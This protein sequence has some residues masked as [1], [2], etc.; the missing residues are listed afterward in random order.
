MYFWS[1]IWTK[2]N[3]RSK[4]STNK[5]WLDRTKVY[6]SISKEKSAACVKWISEILSNCTNAS[7]M[8]TINIW[9]CSIV[10]GVISWI[11]R[12]PFPIRYFLWMLH[13]IVW[14]RLFSDCRCCIR[15]IICIVTSSCKM[16]WLKTKMVKRYILL[17]ADLQNSWFWICQ[18]D[19]CAWFFQQK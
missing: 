14:A 1:R 16:C 13:W 15:A 12:Q 2:N 17:N 11:F 18:E 9:F 3:M 8:I 4:L 5:K 10:M 19:K 6:W 7:K